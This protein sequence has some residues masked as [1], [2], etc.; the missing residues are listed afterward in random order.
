[1][2]EDSRRCRCFTIGDA[3]I[4][5]AATAVG[6]VWCIASLG[7]GRES[8]ADSHKIMCLRLQSSH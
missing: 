3:M 1:M 5:I 4:L 6:I 7:R 2:P 8:T